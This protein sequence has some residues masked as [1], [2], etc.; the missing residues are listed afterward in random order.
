MAWAL[1][2]SWAGHF[3]AEPLDRFVFEM[4]GNV[5]TKPE[6]ASVFDAFLTTDVFPALN[7]FLAAALLPDTGTSI[8][9]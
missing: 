1:P 3:F 9:S 6:D 8:G 5:R 2:D 7:D 4:R